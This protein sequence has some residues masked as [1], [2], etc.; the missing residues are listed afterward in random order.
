MP[1][2]AVLAQMLRSRRVAPRRAKK[3]AV[4]RAGLDDA[5]RSHVTVGQDGGG[6]VLVDKAAQAGG[7]VGDG[8]V[9]ADALEL[10]VALGTNA[11][12]GM[13]HAVRAVDAVQ[14]VIDLGA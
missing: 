12:Q 11:L 13:E 3:A 2:P 8:L 14:V 1:R 9:P 10:A 4:Q 6:A 5:L 7:N